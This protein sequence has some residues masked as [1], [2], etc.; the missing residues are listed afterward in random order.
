MIASVLVIGYFIKF[1]VVQT[2]AGNQRRKALKLKL[3]ED[4]AEDGTK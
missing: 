4:V 2:R 1:I 3:N